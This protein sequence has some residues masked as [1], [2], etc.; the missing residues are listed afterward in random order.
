MDKE[1]FFIVHKDLPREGPG[2]PEEVAWALELAA[3]GEDAVICDA[4]SGPGGD[5]FELLK[6]PGA[7]VVAVDTRDAFVAQANARFAHEGRFR[8][9]CRS[10]E[11]VAGLAEAPFDFIWCAGALYF[12]GIPSGLGAFSKALVPNGVVAFSEPCYFTDT[13]SEM[14]QAFWEGYN[15]KRSDAILK[16]VEAQGFEVMAHR[17]VSDAGWEAYYQP[18][19]MRIATLRDGAGAALTKMLDLCAAEAASWREVRSETGYLL[20]VAR[21]RGDLG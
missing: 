4:G 5:S 19:E 1:N 3:V 21:R 7:L 11:D 9:E 15:T 17:K 20:I 8:A 10:M 6:A 16:D 12:L 2:S 13:P 14:A 18:M